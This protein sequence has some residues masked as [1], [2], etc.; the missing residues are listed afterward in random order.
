MDV[1]PRSLENFCILFL[2]NLALYLQANRVKPLPAGKFVVHRCEA[3]KCRDLLHIVPQKLGPVYVEKGISET[4]IMRTPCT[5]FSSVFIEF[6]L[7]KVALGQ[8]FF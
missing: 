7:D 4:E 3:L 8:I 6:V 5:V 2:N 1:I